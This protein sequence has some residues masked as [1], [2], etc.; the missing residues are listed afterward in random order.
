MS[1]ATFQLNFVPIR[2]MTQAESARHCGRSLIR[3]KVECP[4]QP[5]TYPN[6]DKRYDVKDLDAWI[7]SL[8][9]GAGSN[10]TDSILTKLGA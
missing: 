5:V 8:K 9:A 3:F 7:D 6:G 10:D 1:S 2:M 4:V